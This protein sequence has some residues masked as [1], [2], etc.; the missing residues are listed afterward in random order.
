MLEA[1]FRTRDSN[2][3]K[4]AI[5]EAAAEAFASRGYLQTGVRDIAASAGVN[6]TLIARYF[7]SKDQLFEAVLR[8][9]LSVEVLLTAD[10]GR[11][12]EHVARLLTADS[13]TADVVAMAV[14]A[15]ADLGARRA[16]RPDARS[17]ASRTSP[18]RLGGANAAER[19]VQITVLC[20]GFVTYRRLLPLEA[21]AGGPDSLHAV[22]L[23]QAL[24]R[25]VDA[26]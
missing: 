23:A 21:A 22:W 4:A 18:G 19:A 9:A 10:R 6:S 24:Q 7:G 8:K 13:P 26:E 15:A 16:T 3:T 20:T 1:T 17:P 25:I 12:G 14:F 5:L 2:R 11:F